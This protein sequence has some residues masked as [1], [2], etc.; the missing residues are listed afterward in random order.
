MNLVQNLLMI[1][2][3]IEIWHI[4]F[5]YCIAPTYMKHMLA[6]VKLSSKITDAEK[7]MIECGKILIDNP[8]LCY[9]LGEEYFE[10]LADT[11][12]R[13]DALKGNNILH[14]IFGTCT[15]R[16]IVSFLLTQ[17]IEVIYIV[18]LFIIM[19]NLPQD[20]AI[21]VMLT[22]IVLSFV[23]KK[24]SDQ[25]GGLPFVDSMLCIIMYALVFYGTCKFF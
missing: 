23:N 18:I 20:V 10:F 4:I 21:P 6:A 8:P 13:Y 1:C 7:N 11:M 15:I 22:S 19:F 24:Y 12:K 25:I 5:H 16:E 17:L 9:A 2:M 14:K 3:L